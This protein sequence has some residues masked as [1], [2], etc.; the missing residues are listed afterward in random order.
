MQ[1]DKLLALRGEHRLNDLRDSCRSLADSLDMTTE[2]T[3]L[4][5]IVGALLMFVC[6]LI[7]RPFAA[8]FDRLPLL[9]PLLMGAIVGAGVA[10]RLALADNAAIAVYLLPGVIGGALAF[11]QNAVIVAGVEHRLRVGARVTARLAF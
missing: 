8:L 5:G 1:L 11:G 2:F 3:R 9:W 7:T 10:W 4:D 6:W